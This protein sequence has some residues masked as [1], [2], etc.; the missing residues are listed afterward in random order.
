M[1]TSIPSAPNEVD[2]HRGWRL[3]GPRSPIERGQGGLLIA[4]LVLTV[5][6]WALTI[7]QAQ[8]MDMAMGVVPRGTSVTA[9]ATAPDEAMGDMAMDGASDMA[10]TGMAGTGWSVG[11]LVAFVGAWAVMMAAMMFPAAAPMVL[12]FR[13]VAT[14]RRTR[15]EAFVP[16]WIFV[17]GYLLVWTAIGVLTW[18]VVQGGSDLVG[19]LE[20]TARA[21]WGPL[22]LGVVLIGAGLYQ[23][24]P[25]KRLCLDH[26]RSPL[27]FVMTHWRDGRLGAL[28]MGLS[29]GAYC[30][31]CW[32][33]FAVLVAAGV[34]SL[35]WMLLLTL[36]V[37]AEKVLPGGQ[38][39]SLVV[40]IALVTLGIGVG[41]GVVA[42]PWVA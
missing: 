7:Y 22:A 27:A 26:C 23:L 35:A 17:A 3:R 36:I 6:A 30:L 21:T 28:R 39:A 1:A 15:G 34:M 32:A 38:R 13:T 42:M 37:F 5:G 19:R 41:G 18:V 33:L 20:A 8:T 14:Q 11:G 25:L 29:H 4:L 10:A 9:D 40:G 16:T 2:T 31:G 24:T 12:L